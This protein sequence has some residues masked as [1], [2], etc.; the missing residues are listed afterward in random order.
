M[1][2]MKDGRKIVL[3]LK[4]DSKSLFETLALLSTP[5][6]L[7]SVRNAKKQIRK[8]ETYSLKEVFG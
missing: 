4:K 2:G 3:L 7:M 6:L 5:G 8:G 1:P